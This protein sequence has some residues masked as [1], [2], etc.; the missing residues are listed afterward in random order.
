MGPKPSTLTGT[1]TSSARRIVERRSTSPARSTITARAAQTPRVWRI[2]DP[3]PT[4][5]GELTPEQIGARIVIRSRDFLGTVYG[6]L[7]GV[8]AHP[9]F[10]H[11]T[12]VQL[13]KKKELTFR[14]D[15][16]VLVLN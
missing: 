15:T 1:R 7:L 12:T 6:T 10:T 16:E 4:T 2:E 9:G 13:W 3:E 5:V 14:N 8:Q 11:F